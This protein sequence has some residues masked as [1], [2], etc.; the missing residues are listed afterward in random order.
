VEAA[1][2]VKELIDTESRE[3]LGMAGTRIFSNL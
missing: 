2:R 3:L 1:A